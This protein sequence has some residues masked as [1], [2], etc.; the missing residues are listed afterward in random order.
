MD[1]ETDDALEAYGLSDNVENKILTCVP[2]KAYE[3][4]GPLCQRYNRLTFL[5]TSGISCGYTTLEICAN[6]WWVSECAQWS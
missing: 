6:D 5:L 2:V 3:A 1:E 4:C